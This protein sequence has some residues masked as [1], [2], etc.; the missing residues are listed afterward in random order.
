M[1]I[2]AIGGLASM[3]TADVG[4][5]LGIAGMAGA[6]TTTYLGVTSGYA[7]A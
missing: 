7:P 1:C 5:K 2:G 4:C 3:K 6:L